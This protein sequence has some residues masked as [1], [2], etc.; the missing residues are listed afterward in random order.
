MGPFS[1]FLDEIKGVFMRRYTCTRLLLIHN[2]IFG[3]VMFGG[4][5]YDFRPNTSLLVLMLISWAVVVI[6]SIRLP[7][8]IEG[9]DVVFCT[10]PFFKRVKYADIESLAIEAKDAILTMRDGSEQRISYGGHIEQAIDRK[11]IND[12]NARLRDA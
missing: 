5:Y 6:F 2:I 9:E 8:K 4:A 7:I 11:W 3:I 1:R 10:I 12:F